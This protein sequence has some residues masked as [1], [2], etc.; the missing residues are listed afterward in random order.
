MLFAA[1]G[2]AEH[3]NAALKAAL[4]LPHGTQ[5]RRTLRQRIIAAVWAARRELIE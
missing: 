5:P 3:D 4:A 2:A 1:K